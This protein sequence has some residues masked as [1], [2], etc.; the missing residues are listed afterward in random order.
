MHICV[1]RKKEGL[2]FPYMTMEVSL[3]TR[4]IVEKD[5]EKLMLKRIKMTIFSLHLWRSANFMTIMLPISPIEEMLV[6]V[7][8]AR[9]TF[10]NRGIDV[11]G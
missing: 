10:K 1:T 3:C 5:E 11:I 7:I 8:E 9:L 6:L 4:V 2:W